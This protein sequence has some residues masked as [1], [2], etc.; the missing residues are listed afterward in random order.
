[1]ILRKKYHD[2][3]YILS[4]RADEF[5]AIK[6]HLFATEAAAHAMENTPDPLKY[7]R[8]PPSPSKAGRQ[9]PSSLPSLPLKPRKISIV[10]KNKIPELP[11]SILFPRMGRTLPDLAQTRPSP[12]P[13]RLDEGRGQRLPARKP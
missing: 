10:I 4:K 13:M 11:L 1:M 5:P 6:S 12:S 7:K 2:K 8:N 9:I 3:P